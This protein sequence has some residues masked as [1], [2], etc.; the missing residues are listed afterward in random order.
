L[1]GALLLSDVFAYACSN[2]P[3]Q[4]SMLNHIDVLKINDIKHG[5]IGVDKQSCIPSR[6][7]P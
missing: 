6:N 1:F 4:F 7:V 3:Y 2:V 5:S